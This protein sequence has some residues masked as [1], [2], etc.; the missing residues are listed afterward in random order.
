MSR[1]PTNKQTFAV[2]DMFYLGVYRL[3]R[4]KF[5]TQTT[6]QQPKSEKEYRNSIPPV[7][8]C[9]VIND[10]QQRAACNS[11]ILDSLKTQE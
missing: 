8:L 2:H 9:D 5:S 4:V 3:S 11:H 6:Y 10:F 7:S 1:P